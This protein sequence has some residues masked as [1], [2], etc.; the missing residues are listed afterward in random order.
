MAIAKPDAGD[1]FRSR[2]ELRRELG[3]GGMGEVHLAYDSYRQ[4]EVAIK[5]AKLQAMADAD[6]QRLKKM[7]VN[8]TRLAGRLQHPYIVEIYESGVAGDQGY[9]VMEYVDGGTLKQ[10]TTHGR[11]LEFNAV[12]EILYKVCSALDYA[13]KMGLLH[14]DIKPANVMLKADGTVKV[15]DFGTCYQT[16]ADETQ[17]FDVGTLPFMPPEHFKRRAPTVQSDIYAAGVMAYQLLTGTLPFDATSHESLIYQ[18]LYGDFIPLEQRRRDVSPELRFVVHRAIHKDVE[19]RYATWGAFSDALA[20]ALPELALPRE[21]Q[22]DSARFK[23]LKG[24]PF[25][26][27]FSEE[28]LWETVHLSTWLYKSKG[29]TVFEAGSP[30]RNVYVITNGAVVVSRDGTALNR[31]QTGACFGEVAYL[32]DTGART[33]TVSAAIGT[34]LIE[35]EAGALRQASG[36][37]QAAFARAFMRVMVGLIK[38]AD[39]RYLQA[40]AARGAG[41]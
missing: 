3:R 29:E 32:D 27:D 16:D 30:G 5:L 35:I 39:T 40:L 19:V 8:E 25:F 4:R 33:A 10:H 20:M 22:F 36:G 18:K 9:L 34:V 14:R 1:A 28:Q 13:A 2:F 24:L 26:A 21:T 11:L 31:L 12:I 15:T 41:P 23:V 6:D 7:W 38:N 17:V 37:L